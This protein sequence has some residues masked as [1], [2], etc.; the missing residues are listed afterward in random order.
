M[1]TQIFRDSLPLEPGVYERVLKQHFRNIALQLVH[2]SQHDHSLY[3]C[4]GG[5]R[6]REAKGL[7]DPVRPGKPMEV[8]IT[9]VI[10]PETWYGTEQVMVKSAV[11][12]L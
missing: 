11:E 10:G 8:A 12:V 7:F 9:M 6:E 3:A 5:L 4:V 2:G 1:T